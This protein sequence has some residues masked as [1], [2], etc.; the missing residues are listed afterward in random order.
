MYD[1]NMI[2]WQ[3]WRFK[4]WM[5]LQFSTARD[6]FTLTMLQY[7]SRLSVSRNLVYSTYLPSQDIIISAL[8]VDLN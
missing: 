1:K 2:D 8:L 4:S 5:L 7:V 3:A 6:V